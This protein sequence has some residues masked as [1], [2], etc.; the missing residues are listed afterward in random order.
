MSAKR[1]QFVI[2]DVGKTFGGS[3][4]R[5]TWKFWFYGDEE[6]RWAA[7]ASGLRRLWLCGQRAELCCMRILRAVLR[8]LPPESLPRVPHAI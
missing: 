2:E 8:F 1:L 5:V 6:V 7:S 4:K 3:K